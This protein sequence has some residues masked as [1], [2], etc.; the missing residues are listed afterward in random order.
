VDAA[1]H[2]EVECSVRYKGIWTPVF[3]CAPHLP[4]TNTSNTSSDSVMYKRV[5]AASDIED[6]TELSCTITFTLVS[7][8]Q[9]KS[10][11]IPINPETPIY[12]FVWKTPAIRI[13]NASGKTE[14]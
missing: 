3:I 5:I 4:G 10:P 1:D 11:V 12:D 9:T 7:G 14:A 13:V 6:S 2:V 8:Y